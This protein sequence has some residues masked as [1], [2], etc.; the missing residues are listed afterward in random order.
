M[1]AMRF[2]MGMLGMIGFWLMPVLPFVF[3]F[4]LLYAIK[5]LMKDQFEFAILG[6][7]AS[8]SLLL[9]LLGIIDYIF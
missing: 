9:M 8:V 3:V 1:R 2:F 5:L 6:G 7:V 4:S